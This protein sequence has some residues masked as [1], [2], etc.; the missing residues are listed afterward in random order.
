MSGNYLWNCHCCVAPPLCS[1]PGCTQF[2]CERKTPKNYE[3]LCGDC[4]ETIGPCYSCQLLPP[5][6]S[7]RFCTVCLAEAYRFHVEH[8]LHESWKRYMA[9]VLYLGVASKQK[10]FETKKT[11]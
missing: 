9:R 2:T 5:W 3:P 10:N 8:G 4:A 7:S 1:M 11:S 6:R